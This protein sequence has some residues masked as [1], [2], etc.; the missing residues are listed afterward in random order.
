MPVPAVERLASVSWDR[1]LCLVERLGGASSLE[2]VQPMC[3]PHG[4]RTRPAWTTI[5]GPIRPNKDSRSVDTSS[6][7]NGG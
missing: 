1:R 2:Q 5:G 3:E 7:E 6:V 4:V